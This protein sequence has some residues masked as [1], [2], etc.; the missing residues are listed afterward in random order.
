VLVSE[1]DTEINV[2][3]IGEIDRDNTAHLWRRLHSGIAL[4]SP[5][6]MVI[7]LAGAPLVDVA[8]AAVLRDAYMSAG[9]AH[10]AVTFVGLQP[11]VGSV[12]AV[13]G[14]PAP[15]VG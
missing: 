15:I 9:I 6:R 2:E 12:L 8:G 1:T 7:N 14:L 11:L 3:V 10:V 4:A 13:V 5:G